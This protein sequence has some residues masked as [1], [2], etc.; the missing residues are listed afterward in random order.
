MDKVTH[1]P[2]AGS[3]S[4]FVPW[5]VDVTIA[6]ALADAPPGLV[7]DIRGHKF[8]QYCSRHRQERTFDP[9][10]VGE[11]HG[12][13]DSHPIRLAFATKMCA[14]LRMFCQV[15]GGT[16]TVQTGIDNTNETVEPSNLETLLIHNS[17]PAHYR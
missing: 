10:R 17:N 5:A 3:I 13:S 8:S 7:A 1:D 15:R 14:G 4:E 12:I 9:V 11:D 6:F 2:R 16:N